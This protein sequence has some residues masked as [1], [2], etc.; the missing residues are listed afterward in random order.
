[1]RENVDLPKSPVLAQALV[2]EVPPEQPVVVV[3]P[4]KATNPRNPIGTLSD[5]EKR[6]RELA[7]PECLHD[8]H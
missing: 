1:M 7:S 2:L 3:Q 5:R 4:E 6:P 8:G